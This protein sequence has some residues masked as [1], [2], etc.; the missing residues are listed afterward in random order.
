MLQQ[1]LHIQKCRAHSMDKTISLG[2]SLETGTKIR[3]LQKSQ[4][5][6]LSIRHTKNCLI[7]T[8]LFQ[9]TKISYNNAKQIDHHIHE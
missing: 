2:P 7:I 9:D 3:T 8:L 5:I 4:H 6:H 1:M